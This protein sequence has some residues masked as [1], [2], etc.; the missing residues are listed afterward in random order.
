M[1]T[2]SCLIATNKLPLTCTDW[3]LILVGCWKKIWVILMTRSDFKNQSRSTYMKIM[4]D[5]CL[6]GIKHY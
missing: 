4:P 2:S 6:N 1:A 5:S 3:H